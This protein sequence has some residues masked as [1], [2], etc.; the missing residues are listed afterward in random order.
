MFNFF[1]KIQEEVHRY[2]FRM[3]DSSRRKNVRGSSLDQI[4]GI[5]EA[6]AKLLLRTFG[7]LKGVKNASLDELMNVKGIN[8][9]VAENIIEYFNNQEN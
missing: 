1:Y 8:R 7:T 9:T 2:S 6:K 3:M 5:G 4:D